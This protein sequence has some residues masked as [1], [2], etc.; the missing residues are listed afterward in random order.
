MSDISAE[1]RLLL[2]G[3][4]GTLTPCILEIIDAHSPDCPIV[5]ELE[6]LL[7]IAGTNASWIRTNHEMAV[8]LLAMEEELRGQA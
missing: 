6:F 7:E 1:Q 3:A 5:T 4:I 8:E 2:A